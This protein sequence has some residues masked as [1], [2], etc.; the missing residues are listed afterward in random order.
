MAVG[1]K[2]QSLSAPDGL[3]MTLLETPAASGGHALEIE[4]R[5]PPGNRLVAADHYHPDGP[6]VWRVLEGTAGYRLDGR[7]HTEAAP[8]E[9]TVPAGTSHGHPWNAGERTLVVRQL[10]A[11]P[12]EPIAELTGGVQGFFET[13]F[14]YSQT[15]GLNEKGEISD[16]LQWALTIHD[17]LMPG[18]FLAGVPRV[19]QGPAFA[20][21]AAIARAFGRS[22]YREPRF[23]SE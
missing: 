19:V 12:D 16:R 23:D 20:A 15:E 22:A 9:Y 5:V 13:L 14:A 2:G 1:E 18:S 21:I 6:E 11:S 17:L 4:W 3:R 10:I 8:H 7:E